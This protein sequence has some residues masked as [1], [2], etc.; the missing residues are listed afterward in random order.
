MITTLRDNLADHTGNFRPE[1]DVLTE[2]QKINGHFLSHQPHL[3]DQ[4]P[5]K[6]LKFQP[7]NKKM[8][9]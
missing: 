4:F 8:D 3:Y 2:E 7:I 1:V 5:V 6:Q 9:N